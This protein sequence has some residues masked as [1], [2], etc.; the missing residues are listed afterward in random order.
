MITILC[1]NAGLDLTYE[2]ASLRV[3]GYHHPLQARLGAGGA[4]GINAARVLRAL[5]HEVR[6]TGF[7]GGY[8]GQEL[9]RLLG[10][11]GIET[12]LVPIAGTSRL[13]L[14]IVDRETRSQT[15]VDE[16]GPPVSDAEVAVLR[17]RWP[18][19]LRGSELAVVA[20]TAPPGV[21][22]TLCGE[23]V[24]QGHAQGVPVLCDVRDD[25][26]RAVA[27]ERPELIKPNREEFARFVGRPLADT[28]AVLAAAREVVA[29]GVPTV[30][31]TL[32]A[33]GA[34]AVDGDGA[35]RAN[36]PAV[37]GVSPVG[38]GDA[39]MAGLIHA[40]LRGENLAGQLRWAVAAGAANATVLGAGQVGREQIVG[41]L[42]E[43]AL[44]AL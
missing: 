16:V 29:R 22:P 1:A 3:G 17:A 28:A 32:G 37:D 34:L 19:T 35:W 24:A 8:V 4:K 15:Q 26:L 27:A 23:L 39:A 2:V 30:V 7:A 38:S 25:Y 10:E 36:P 6:V 41:L 12:D 40:R 21:P 13:C 33:E 31:V 9:G 18:E 20:G 5:G 43:V 44:C 11:A 42:P 14:N